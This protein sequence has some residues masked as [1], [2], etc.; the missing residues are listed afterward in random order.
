[1]RPEPLAIGT[2]DVRWSTRGNLIV[3]GVTIEVRPGSLVGLLGPNGSG[4]TSLLRLL[5]NMLSPSSGTVEI[6]GEELRKLDRRRTAQKL[7]VLTQ[8]ATTQFRPLVKD[9]VMLGR[10]PHQSGMRGPSE[11]DY[12]VVKDSLNYVGI[13]HLAERDY[14]TL[15][16]GERQR[17]QLARTLAQETPI[18]LLDEPSNHLDVSH[19]YGL[20][21][22]VKDLGV[23][24]IAALHDLNL[25]AACCDHLVVLSGGRIVAS[26]APR[27]VVT[28]ELVDRVWDVP[29]DVTMTGRPPRP[30]V[31]FY[32]DRLP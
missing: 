25:A 13:T 28:S 18:L 11:N 2:N 17:A 7:A 24:T 30:Q 29:C 1:M 12:A 4:K 23:T 32:P 5:A 8:E 26:G 6:A 9:V 3:K 14:P 10:I 19:Q 21:H 15:S 31:T 27:E 16:G 20:L 22:T